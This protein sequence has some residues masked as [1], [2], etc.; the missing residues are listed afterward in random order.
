MAN[1]WALKILSGPHVGAEIPLDSGTWTLGRHEE[2]DLILTDNSLAERQL[3]FQVSNEGVQ[4]TNLAQ[5]QQIYI[6][7][8]PQPQSFIL[9]PFAVAMA[10]SLYFAVG[11]TGQP[12]PELNLGGPAVNNSTSFVSAPAAQPSVTQGTQ[13]TQAA[14]VDQENSHIP[15]INDQVDQKDLEAFHLVED[16]DEIINRRAPSLLLRRFFDG[17]RNHPVA[18]GSSLMVLFM[19]SLVG[20][21][22]WLWMMTDPEKTALEN[23]T[24]AQTA[25]QIIQQMNAADLT[26]EEQPDGSVIISGY[27]TDNTLKNSLQQALNSAKVP[28]S[29]QGIVMNEMRAVAASVLDRYD[30]KQ[31]NIEL[32]TTPGSLVLSGYAANPKEVARIRDILHQE[33]HGLSSLIDQV[34]YQVT[35]MKAL[36]TMLKERNLSQQIR[37]QETPGQIVLRGRLNDAAQGYYLKEIVQNFRDKYKDRPKLV[38]DVTLP[39]TDLATMQPLLKIKSVSLGRVPYVI[40]ANGEKYL[41]GARLKN[42]YILESINLEYLT[43]RLGQERMK[44]FIAT[45]GEGHGG[46]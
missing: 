6:S 26:L 19:S 23:I 38:V 34:E 14:Q 43:L 7:G 40:L 41:Q 9:Q 44:Y 10:G 12:W 37:L 39:S 18:I 42:G 30:F 29:F 24:S 27:I 20:A 11:Q 15:V 5:G 45:K 31:M 8:E 1:I 28:Y 35:R 33:V 21:F 22:I 13:G 17:L 32:D 2:C 16:P 46:Q 36:R 4:V 3:E 25:A